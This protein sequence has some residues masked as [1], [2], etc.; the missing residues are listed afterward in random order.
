MAEITDGYSWWTKC[1]RTDCDLHIVRPGDAACNHETCLEPLNQPKYTTQ[2]NTVTQPTKRQELWAVRLHDRETENDPILA[3]LMRSWE[4]EG[5]W[6]DIA[7]G[8]P[9]SMWELLELNGLR[10]ELARLRTLCE[11]NDIDWWDGIDD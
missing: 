2:E 7:T 11:Q 4:P 1:E 8:H 10:D 3:T 5:P 9:D 6:H